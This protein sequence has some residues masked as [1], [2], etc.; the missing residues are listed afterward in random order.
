MCKVLG[1]EKDY[2]VLWQYRQHITVTSSSIVTNSGY[3]FQPPS[4]LSPTDLWERLAVDISRGLH[5]R[6]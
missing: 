2:I 4:P 1:R 6:D 5:T 3:S